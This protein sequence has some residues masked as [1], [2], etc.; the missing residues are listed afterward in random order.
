MSWRVR[1]S[2]ATEGLDVREQL[3]GADANPA[4][5]PAPAETHAYAHAGRKR[6]AHLVFVATLVMLAAV[7]FF[8]FRTIRQGPMVARQTPAASSEASVWYRYEVP[9]GGFSLALPPSWMRYTKRLP[10]FEPEPKFAAWGIS[11]ER[12]GHPW[13]YVVKRPIDTWQETQTYFERV[14]LLVTLDPGSVRVSELTEIQFLDGVGYTFTSVHKDASG[15][16]SETLYGMLHDGYEYR[17]VFVVPL[18]YKDDHDWLF[19]D[20]AK[21]FDIIDILA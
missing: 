5:T 19:D 10:S 21:S 15:R 14:R 17:L 9:T 7:G 8:I 6:V 18:K 3:A 1:R 4:E 13:L 20:I 11:G 16:R 12:P 2:D